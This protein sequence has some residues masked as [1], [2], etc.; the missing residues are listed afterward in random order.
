MGAARAVPRA[1]EAQ[2]LRARGPGW[3]GLPC[4]C[5]SGGAARAVPRAPESTGPAGLK[6]HGPAGEKPR[7]GGPEAMILRAESYGLAGLK[8]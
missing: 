2:A 4:G 5:G 8:P 7:S 6:D 3:P 1:P